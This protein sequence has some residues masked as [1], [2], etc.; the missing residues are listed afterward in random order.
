MFAA[1]SCASPNQMKLFSTEIQ[2]IALVS[3]NVFAAQFCTSPKLTLAFPDGILWMNLNPQ[4]YVRRI[5]LTSPKL[6][7]D[8][9]NKIGR[10]YVLERINVFEEIRDMVPMEDVARFYGLELNRSKMACCPFHP[11]NN[12]SMKIYDD[13]YHCFGCGMHGDATDFVARLFQTSQIDAAK[14]ISLD[15]GLNLFDRNQQTVS[16]NAPARALENPELQYKRW[17]RDS[18]RALN[19]Y[20]N[21]L[22]RWKHQYKPTEEAAAA[23][24]LHPLF[25]ESISRMDYAN[26]LYDIVKYGEESEKRDFYN[27]WGKEA[28]YR[29]VQRLIETGLAQSSIKKRTI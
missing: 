27:G 6:D 10:W 8:S 14:R 7:L 4:K 24:N 5:I 23:G 15:F 11:D 22:C 18:E 28:M 20:L 21:A 25:L 1:W 16:Q 29:I 26:H 3:R 9:G 13:H 12:P 17:L 19:I 2:R